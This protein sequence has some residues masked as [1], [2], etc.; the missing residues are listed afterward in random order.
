MITI[1]G[2][3]YNEPLGKGLP[4]YRIDK[5]KGIAAVLPHTALKYIELKEHVITLSAFYSRAVAQTPITINTSK[6]NRLELSTTV[7][8]GRRIPFP[9]Y[10]KEGLNGPGY[11]YDHINNDEADDTDANLRPVSATQNSYNKKLAKNNTTG[12]KGVTKNGSGN[13]KAG[14]SYEYN[15]YSGGTYKTRIAAAI[16]YNELARQ[17]HGEFARPNEIT[18]EKLYEVYRDPATRT[19]LIE[20]LA[21]LDKRYGTDWS[22]VLSA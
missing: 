7:T 11:M 1:N 4:Y 16:S 6:Y 8:G 13:Y 21:K 12:F 22:R 3:E 5:E 20:D 18:I 9:T 2:R 10:I 17:Y 15:Y 14:I 19:F